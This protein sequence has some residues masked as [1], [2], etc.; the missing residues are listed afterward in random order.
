MTDAV[1]GAGGAAPMR[2]VTTTRSSTPRSSCSTTDGRPSFEALQRHDRPAAALLFDVLALDGE[3]FVDL[4]QAARRARLEQ[5][6]LNGSN[7]QTPPTSTDGAAAFETATRLGLEGVV[8]KRLDARYLPGRRSPAWRKVKIDQTQEFVVGG[9]LP[10]AN[11][12]EGRLGSLLV[13]VHDDEG[14]L[15][16]SGR[17][18]SGISEAARV[19]A[20]RT[21]RRTGGVGTAVQSIHPTSPHAVWARPELVVEVRFTEWTTAGLLRQPRFRGLRDD[22]DP[23]AV[24]REDL[25]GV[26]AKPLVRLATLGVDLNARAGGSVD[27]DVSASPRMS[28]SSPSSSGRAPRADFDVVVRTA[29]GDPLVIRNAPLLVD[30]TPMPTRY[31]LVDPDVS[32]AVAQLESAGGVRRAD[33]EVDADDLRAAAHCLRSG[34]RRRARPDAHGPSALGWCGRDAYRREVPARALRLLPG[35]W[36]RSGRRLDRR[37]SA[38]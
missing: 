35:R 37:S 34:A 14:R 2:S 13:G 7:W 15:G 38:R 23:A 36:R 33:A 12:L 4:T 8:A 31:W 20:R 30:G 25:T 27:S 26:S 5:L 28:I 32:R 18:G 21:P 24:V 22:K 29:T 17:V 6:G 1:P 11:R 10:G 3:S 19:A 16:Y 9:W